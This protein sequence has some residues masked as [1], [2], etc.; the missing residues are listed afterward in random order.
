MQ[1]K[2]FMPPVAAQT[3]ETPIGRAVGVKLLWHNISFCSLIFMPSMPF[4]YCA[5]FSMVNFIGFC[6][7]IDFGF[8]GIVCA[9][10]YHLGK[11]V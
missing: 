5:I 2:G 7:W 6:E 10:D 3:E 8:F 1:V 4:V 11:K 9:R